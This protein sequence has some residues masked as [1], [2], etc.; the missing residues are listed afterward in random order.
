MYRL[1]RLAWCDGEDIQYLKSNGEWECWDSDLWLDFRI[2]P[3]WRVK[4]KTFTVSQWERRYY[5]AA[6]KKV[7][8]AIS[9]K[10]ENLNSDFISWIDEAEYKTYE[11][12][13]K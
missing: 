7:Q 8:V 13:H 10:K 2:S 11:V 1:V 12:E 4:P 9:D 3:Q 6:S 5:L